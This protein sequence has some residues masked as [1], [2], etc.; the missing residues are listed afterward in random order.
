MAPVFH[1][2]AAPRNAPSFVFG[3]PT[4]PQFNNEPDVI[5]IDDDD[6]D[7]QVGDNE[8][9]V[10]DMEQDES[11]NV[12]DDEEVTGEDEES[13]VDNDEE[14]EEEEERE[15]ELTVESLGKVN[16]IDS[17]DIFN[18]RTLQSSP[19]IQEAL[20][21]LRHTAD[22]VT[23]QMQAFAEKLDK[24]KQQDRDQDATYQ[25]A[26][27]LI[28]SYHQNA[29]DAIKDA[30][31]QSTIQKAKMGWNTSRVA[32]QPDAKSKED[33]RRLQL[34]VDTWDLF[35]NLIALD[36]PTAQAHCKEAQKSV[37]Q[38][39]H[40]YS[41]DKEI[42][43]QFLDADKYAAECAMVL[44]WL[45]VKA[46][47][48]SQHLDAMIANLEAQADRGSGLWAHGWLYTKESIKGQKRL[49]AWP[50][51]LEPG[52]PGLLA[53]LLDSDNKEPLITQLDPDA[54]IRQKHGLQKQDKF[55][56][57]ATWL[58]CWKM[59]RQGETWEKIQEWSQERLEG[60]RAVSLCGS[61]VEDQSSGTKKQVGD[62]MTRMMNCQ[63]QDT[64]R[65]ACS[66]LA[67]NPNTGDYEKAVY[68]LLSGETEP[69]YHVCQSWDDYLYVFYNN[70]LLSRYREFC[71]QF[72]RKLSHSPLASV[73]FVPGPMDY[74]AIKRFLDSLKSHESVGMEARNPYST[75]QAA[76]LGR[77]F[78]SFFLSMA[79]AASESNKAL[80]NES[81]VPD[82]LATGVD[83]SAL[84]AVR[85]KDALRIISHMYIVTQ[86]LSYTRSDAH[87]SEK[88]ALN[89]MAYAENLHQAGLTDWIPLY[90]S[91]MPPQL[92]PK[93]VV[94]VLI[95]IKETRDQDRMSNL[96]ERH[97]IDMSAVQIAL[98]KYIVAKAPKSEKRTV[99]FDHKIRRD[100]AKGVVILLPPSKKFT[101]EIMSAKIE[102]VIRCVEWLTFLKAKWGTI[103][104]SMEF[105][106]KRLFGNGML[107]EARELSER[108]PLSELSQ[109]VLGYD[110]RSSAFFDDLSL[111]DDNSVLRSPTKS[112]SK[113]S[114]FRRPQTEDERH[115]RYNEALVLIDLEFVIW[116]YVALDDFREAWE[117]LEL[118]VALRS[119]RRF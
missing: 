112:P 84:I 96:L 57:E 50:Q 3:R 108:L 94:R 34:E 66:A 24:F 106:Y 21:P 107:L 2:P 80:L 36:E 45:E 92:A 72:S 6:D 113:S 89:V 49:R 90:A 53:S 71:S 102:G 110:I 116:S 58:T 83:S 18:T 105:L 29:S 51:P 25:A 41:T 63:S 14:E 73:P 99:T 52:S 9:S 35:L 8:N 78:D 93:V 43:L 111:V 17:T 47:S 23:R 82:I 85:D 22:R 114:R 27:S 46:K 56:E 109:K 37:F 62:S 79:D 4:Q 97:G 26:Y 69:A 13:N 87:F 39:L 81:L 44:R 68:A 76:I 101:G 61:R 7:E 42:W 48:S 5:E 59:L 91:F 67:R 75:I 19:G 30:S 118:Y 20:H 10:D 103:C 16:G 77:N 54:V 100:K 40:R 28:K 31:R 104:A 60:W 38:N 115:E 33:L 70:I 74:N 117:H 64:W 65:A 88:G 98:A 15:E 86:R 32:D 12:E 55:Y 1:S 119:S 11:D 95:D